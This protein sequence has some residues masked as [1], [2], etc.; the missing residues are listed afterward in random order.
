[1]AR[2]PS[3]A[4]FFFLAALISHA[5][6]LPLLRRASI[7]QLKADIQ[8]ATGDITGIAQ[9]V[10]TATWAHRLASVSNL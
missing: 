3:A 4:L 10:A 9:Q 1:M 5:F 8:L 7:S 6:S 2:F